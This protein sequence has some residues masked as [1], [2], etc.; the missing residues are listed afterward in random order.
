VYDGEAVTLDLDGE[1]LIRWLLKLSF[2]SARA[3]ESDVRLLQGY[4]DA[5]LGRGSLPDRVRGYV[6]TGRDI[7]SNGN[8][9]GCERRT[10]DPLGSSPWRKVLHEMGHFPHAG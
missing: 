1:R 8:R 2:N 9:W 5:I 4:R 3:Q 7:V 6:T 10:T